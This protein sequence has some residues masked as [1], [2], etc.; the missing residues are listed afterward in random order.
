MMMVVMEIGTV[1]D[2][3][4]EFLEIGEGLDVANIASK[5]D[6]RSPLFVVDLVKGRIYAVGSDLFHELEVLFN[7]K[8]AKNRILHLGKRTSTFLTISSSRSDWRSSARR[9]LIFRMFLA[10]WSSS[11][12]TLLATARSSSTMMRPNSSA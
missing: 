9:M 2:L 11:V 4:E 12:V 5:D 3:L 7:R 6:E 8:L 10:R 1:K